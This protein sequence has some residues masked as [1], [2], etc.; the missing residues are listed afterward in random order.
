ME[1]YGYVTSYQPRLTEGE[2]HHLIWLRGEAETAVLLPLAP[3]VEQGEFSVTVELSTQITRV[4]QELT[5]KVIPEGSLVQR[6]TSLLLDLKNRANVLRFMNIIVDETPIVPYEV[7]RRFI[8]GSPTAH[9]TI[10]GDVIGPIFPGG[11]ALNVKKI[12]KGTNQGEFGF[13]NWRNVFDL[14][15]NTWQLHYLRL[16][17]QWTE[18]LQTIQGVFETMN[19]ILMEITMKMESTGAVRGFTGA[20]ASVWLTSWALRI[21]A[22]AGFQEWEDYIYVDP[23]VC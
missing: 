4:E 10:S 7:H 3:R 9:V 8:S 21:F 13:S 12:F 22:Y 2:H 23:V 11:E 5:I 16:T 17:N 19:T 20:P 1:Q 14:G 6:H 15:L 18:N